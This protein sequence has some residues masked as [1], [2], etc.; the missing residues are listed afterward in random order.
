PATLAAID[1][2]ARE[3]QGNL[4]ALGLTDAKGQAIGS[5]GYLGG[6]SRHAINAFQQQ[7]GLPA[8]GIADAETR[9]ALANEVQQRAQAQGNTQ[10]QQAA[11]E[12]ARETVYPMSDPRSPQ[13]W[14][15]TETL[16]QVKFAEEARGLPSGEHSE[17]LAAALTVEAARAGL[18]RVDRVELNQD[19]SMARAV[20]A[21]ALHDESALNRN[22]APVSTA[23]AM[24]QSVQENSER[25]LQVSD[26]QRE[27]QKIDQQTQQHGPRAMM[28]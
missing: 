13:N 22:T 6:G 8:T 4:A 5:D 7:H 27:Q 10:E 17:K 1:R 20:Q 12:P 21:N 25:A 16:V 2:D 26:Q 15:Y 23:D 14:L 3:L 28:A 19:G 11:A 9:Q 18:Y 24:R